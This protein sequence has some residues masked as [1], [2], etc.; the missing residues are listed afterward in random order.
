MDLEAYVR[1]GNVQG[2]AQRAVAVHDVQEQGGNRQLQQQLLHGGQ[3]LIL[4]LLQL[5]EV[6]HKAN[7]TEAQ[8]QQQYEVHRIVFHK[9][10]IAQQADHRCQDEHQSAHH[11]SAGLLVVPGGT[12]FT[13][14][15]AS[16]QR[17]E[18][19]QQQIAQ[20]AGQDATYQRRNQNSSHK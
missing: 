11:G 14:R 19:R 6:I 4:L 1:K 7:S 20:T 2:A 10:D 8:C 12:D 13:N 3:A 18:H 15:L 9:G 5:G 16:L 17:M